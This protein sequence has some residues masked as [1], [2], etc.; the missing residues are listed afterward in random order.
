MKIR[1]KFS[2]QGVMRFIGHLDIMRYFQKA[3]RRAH[4]D[5]AF[6]EG[7]SPHMIMSF[8]APLGVGLTSDG[9]Y[10]DIEIRTPVSSEDA[11][12]QLN[13]VMV[14]GMKVLSFRQIEEGKAGKAM[15]LV[16]AADYTVSFRPGYEPEGDW[17]SKLEEFIQKDSILVLKKTK[18][19]EVETDIR[20][21]IYQLSVKDDKVHMTLATG[22]AANL[23]PELV[24]SAFLKSEGLDLDPFA[25]SVNRDDVYADIGTE[26]N[27]KLTSLESLGEDIVL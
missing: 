6:T 2:K 25:L 21:M 13:E 14:E 5:I 27:R 9:E 15:S 19:S 17:Q 24:M 10:M 23:K 22:S 11:I 3:M 20:P 7:F 8:A 12:H 4:I 18:K 1:I 16:A 26:E